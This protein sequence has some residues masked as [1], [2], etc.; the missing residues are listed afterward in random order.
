MGPP[1]GTPSFLDKK[2]IGEAMRIT[3]RRN[4]YYFEFTGDLNL[5]WLRIAAARCA[6]FSAVAGKIGSAATASVAD[7]Q[8]E[9]LRP[10]H[11]VQRERERRG[12]IGR[13]VRDNDVELVK[14]EE[15]GHE[16]RE[17]NGGLLP[18]DGSG[19]AGERIGLFQRSR[20]R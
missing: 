16:A 1:I 5:N 12:V 20:R 8:Q 11:T 13:Y 3:R 15:P 10:I 4:P 7:G 19:E 18:A 14:T 6:P 2:N 17:L 9:L